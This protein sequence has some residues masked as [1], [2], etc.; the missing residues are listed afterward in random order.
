MALLPPWQ[1]LM[2]VGF[3]ARG[4]LDALALSSPPS[5]TPLAVA[6]SQQVM[7]CRV[8]VGRQHG[9]SWRWHNRQS[10]TCRKR[11]NNPVVR[12]LGGYGVA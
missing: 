6:S 10:S 3:H 1:R 11:G 8:S 5:G 12:H 2:D 7:C 4:V 9:A